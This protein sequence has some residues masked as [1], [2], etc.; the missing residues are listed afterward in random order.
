[1]FKRFAWSDFALSIAGFLLASHYRVI[2]W[3]NRLIRIPGA[4]FFQPLEQEP[5]IIA[6]W[7]GEPMRRS[8]R[9]AA[10]S[11]SA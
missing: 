9:R 4:T 11:R 10:L 2:G 1:M 6:P 5:V 7:H 8:K 3:T